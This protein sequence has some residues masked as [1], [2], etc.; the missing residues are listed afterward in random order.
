[1][2][3]NRG[4]G[5]VGAAEHVAPD[6]AFLRD[7]HHIDDRAFIGIGG[8][9]RCQVAAAVHIGEVEAASAFKVNH[10]DGDAAR[11]VAVDVG[12]T[13]G[14]GDVAALQVEGDIAVDV[15]SIIRV[16]TRLSFRATKDIGDGA[17]AHVEGDITYNVGQLGAAV[18]FGNRSSTALDDGIHATV[19]GKW[20][21]V[22]AAIELCDVFSTAR[23]LVDFS[24][25]LACN[26]TSIVAAT[27]KGVDGTARNDQ[28]R[29]TIADVGRGD[30]TV[31]ATEDVIHTAT[32][33]GIHHTNSCRS[34]TT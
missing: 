4:R 11:D 3:R 21:Q 14:V 9:V 22:T 17:A 24:V 28:M 33:D 31:T 10:V 19:R 23:I 25:Q 15:G 34:I 18:S 13:K 6:A 26:V 5:T 7:V 30:F 8:M 20:C 27:K 29:A 2:G 1:M 12:A 32:L 16:I